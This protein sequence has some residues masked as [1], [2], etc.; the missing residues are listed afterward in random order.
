MFVT[1]PHLVTAYTLGLFGILTT[2]AYIAQAFE[3]DLLLLKND[4]EEY[5]LVTKNDHEK[6]MLVTKNKNDHENYSRWT[7]MKRLGLGL[8]F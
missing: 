8:G 2:R 7:I 4:H 1:H 3:K 5:M 6:Y